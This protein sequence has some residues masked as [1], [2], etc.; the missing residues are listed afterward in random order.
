M[1]SFGDGEILG[2]EQFVFLTCGVPSLRA[3]AGEER[4]HWY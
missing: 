2:A 4:F 1:D 3:A